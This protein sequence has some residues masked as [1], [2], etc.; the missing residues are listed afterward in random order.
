M[1]YGKTKDYSI[2]FRSYFGH[3]DVFTNSERTILY[4]IPHGYV[5]PKL[6]GKDLEFAFEFEKRHQNKWTYIVD[7]SKVKVANP[8][9]P[10]YLRKLQKLKLMKEYIVYAPSRFVRMM[11]KLSGW[12]SRPDRVLKTEESLLLELE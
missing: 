9:N 3:I 1:D 2:I 7:T 8:L 6:V 4:I 10:F 5:G 11:L 12:I